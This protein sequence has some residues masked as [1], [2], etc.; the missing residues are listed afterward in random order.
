M[1]RA[2][3]SVGSADK[4]SCHVSVCV[5]LTFTTACFAPLLTLK[6]KM[7]NKMFLE[8]VNELQGKA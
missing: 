5:K 4:I 6:I 1:I 2:V 7:K 8:R 3:L